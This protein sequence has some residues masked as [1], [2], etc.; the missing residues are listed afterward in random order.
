MLTF[1]RSDDVH[2][3]Q[4]PELAHRQVGYVKT[5]EQVLLGTLYS[6]L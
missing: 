4:D 2:A 5:L 1:Y 3:N 6:I